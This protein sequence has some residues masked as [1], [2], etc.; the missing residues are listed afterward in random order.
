MTPA[1]RVA[2]REAIAKLEQALTE[3]EAPGRLCAKAWT[4]TCGQYYCTRR[5]DHDGPCAA[6][7]NDNWAGHA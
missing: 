3:D 1:E 7:L 6:V 5:A 4:N 2:I